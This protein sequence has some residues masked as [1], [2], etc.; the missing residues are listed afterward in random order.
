MAWLGTWSNRAGPRYIAHSY[1]GSDQ[2]NV[3][4]MVHISASCGA[5]KADLSAIISAL[6]SNANRKK[7]AFTLSDGTTQCKAECARFDFTNKQAIYRVLIPTASHTTD[8]GIYIY[9]DSAQADNTGYVDDVGNTAAKAVYDSNFVLASLMNGTYNG[10]A[11]EI[12]DSCASATHG[13]GGGGTA[14]QCPTQVTGPFDYISAVDGESAA[15]TNGHNQYLQWPNADNLSVTTTGYIHICFFVKQTATA[16]YIAGADADYINA[17]IY[18]KNGSGLQYN[19]GC[20]GS[21]STNKPYEMFCYALNTDGGSGQGA[22]TYKQ[23]AIGDIL[24]VNFWIDQAGGMIYWRCYY[25]D[26]SIP[27]VSIRRRLELR[28]DPMVERVRLEY[29]DF[30]C[31]SFN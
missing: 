12:K 6:G 23:W 26:G 3:P 24:F 20:G 1:F 13:V 17:G 9:Y 7:I 16:F 27:A 8:T 15:P 10:T 19:F 18:G 11:G 29:V 5:D 21:N 25:P 22:D 30:Q 31:D 28:H 2:A 4:L 14:G